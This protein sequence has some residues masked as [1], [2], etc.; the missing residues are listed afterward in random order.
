MLGNTKKAACECS[1][2]SAIVPV[3][4]SCALLISGC[5][6]TAVPHELTTKMQ[7]DEWIDVLKLIDLERDVRAGQ[8]RF[9]NGILVGFAKSTLE[10]PYEL[11]GEYDVLWEFESES[12]AINLLLASPVEKRFEW[13]MKGWSHQLC[14]IRQVDCKPAND[15]ETTTVYPLISRDRYV[16][17]VRVRDYRIVAM[18][19]G[20]EILNYKTDWSNVEVC[21]P[22]HKIELKP[23][24]LGL[25][26]N[27][28][29]TKTYR[30]QVT[31]PITSPIRRTTKPLATE[32]SD[33]A[34]IL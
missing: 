2:L 25:W 9:E 31:S 16:A 20:E 7:T 13:M 29:W 17:E 27:K 6:G 5:S 23:R 8:W 10:T 34:I 11:P 15:N 14:A 24:T 19:N 1:L 18:I 26:L 22:W 30:L 33:C 21:L 4:A 28:H 32:K 3:V 12:T